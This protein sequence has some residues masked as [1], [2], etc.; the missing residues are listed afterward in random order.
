MS[1]CLHL[2]NIFYP[3]LSNALPAKT[4]NATDVKIIT[5]KLFKT[6]KS[7]LMY[8]TLGRKITYLRISIPYV[9]GLSALLILERREEVSQDTLHPKEKT[10]AL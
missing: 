10:S 4:T 3:F 7:G 8:P 2:A 5:V 6:E 9:K 1:T